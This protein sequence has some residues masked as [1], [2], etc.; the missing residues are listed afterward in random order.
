MLSLRQCDGLKNHQKLEALF[1]TAFHRDLQNRLQWLYPGCWSE[2][3]TSNGQQR[4]QMCRKPRLGPRSEETLLEIP[5]EP[6]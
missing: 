1:G 2:E 4:S 5:E 3:T 6:N